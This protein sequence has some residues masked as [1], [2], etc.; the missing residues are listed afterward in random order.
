MVPPRLVDIKV[1]CERL[2]PTAEHSA[3]LT[4]WRG[5]V[6]EDVRMKYFRDSVPVS[7]GNEDGDDGAGGAE[8][9]TVEKA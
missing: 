1:N 2:I 4:A 6:G 8:S 3:F 5:L 9:G 7:K